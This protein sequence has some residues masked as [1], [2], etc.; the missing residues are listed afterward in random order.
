MPSEV[1]ATET[2]KRERA[3]GNPP[4]GVK[5]VSAVPLGTSAAI[6]RGLRKGSSK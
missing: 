1:K 3:T 4:K 2:V 5:R 6:T